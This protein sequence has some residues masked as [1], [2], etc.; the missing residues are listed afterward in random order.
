MRTCSLLSAVF[1]LFFAAAALAADNHA[2]FLASHRVSEAR[3]LG[4]DKSGRAEL[5]KN[6]GWLFSMVRAEKAPGLAAAEKRLCLAAE[7]GLRDALFLAAAGN[8]PLRRRAALT[9]FR[10]LAGSDARLLRGVEFTT[11]RAD[12]FTVLY[13]IPLDGRVEK[14]RGLIASPA[15]RSAYR[16]AL[17]RMASQQC[18]GISGLRSALDKGASFAPCADAEPLMREVLDMGDASPAEELL[19]GSCL[20]SAGRRGEAERLAARHFASLS[21][22]SAEDA[23]ACGD[24]LY[25]LGREKEAEAAWNAAAEKL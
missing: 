9:A 8:A 20:A 3:P 23:E 24:L 2:D 7:E 21:S 1:L 12:G 13:A 22:L 11:S 19:H 16:G 5:L 25:I 15:F 4:A 10:S 17:R 14:A 18:S 6:G